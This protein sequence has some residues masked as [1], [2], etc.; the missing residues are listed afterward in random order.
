VAGTPRAFQYERLSF[1]A[2]G[3]EALGFGPFAISHLGRLGEEPVKFVSPPAGAYGRPSAW[4]HGRIGV[5]RYGPLDQRL[6][7]LTRGLSLGRI[8]V[9]GYRSLFGTEPES[10]FREELA[11]LLG[12]GLL[13]R[14]G[15]VLEATERGVFHADTIAG[16][17]AA[18]RAA[19]LEDGA[20]G[21]HSTD[22]PVS[23]MG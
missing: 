4:P 7:V 11:L 21:R 20:L 15:E 16:L 8:D 14:E 1:Q 19:E 5:F 23:P 2:V 17:L 12:E 6:L 13:V 9:A 10:D 3:V 22:G 18:R